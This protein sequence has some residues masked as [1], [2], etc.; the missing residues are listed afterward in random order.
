LNAQRN[1]GDDDV[2]ERGMLEAS[3]GPQAHSPGHCPRGAVVMVAPG[4]A[5]SSRRQVMFM[6]ARRTGAVPK[7]TARVARSIYPDGNTIMHMLDV[8]QLAV[9]DEDFA[10]LSPSA[11]SRRSLPRA[12]PS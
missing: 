5:A 3:S 6:L 2:H 4:C 8:L 11:V 7:E 10:D 9:A 12:L 1:N